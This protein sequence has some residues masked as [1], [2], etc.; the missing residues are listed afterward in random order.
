LIAGLHPTIEFCEPEAA[1][2][3]GAAAGDHPERA[4]VI[5]PMLQAIT[6]QSAQ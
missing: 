2:N 5:G 6:D 1:K 3:H 4:L